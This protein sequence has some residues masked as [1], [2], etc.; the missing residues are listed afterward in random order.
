MWLLKML[1]FSTSLMHVVAMQQAFGC[2]H[3]AQH[4]H[5][6]R[7]QV[8]EL[9]AAVAAVGQ[10]AEA[11]SSAPEAADAVASA[12]PVDWGA[13]TAVLPQQPINHTTSL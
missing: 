1:A 13:D 5:E 4:L 2:R 7:S 9:W 6:A 11:S 10:E 8:A 12:P 3:E